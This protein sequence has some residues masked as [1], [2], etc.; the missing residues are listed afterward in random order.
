MSIPNELDNSDLKEIL[1]REDK[2]K[3]LEIFCIF[4]MSH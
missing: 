1:E 3:K 2:D 4:Y